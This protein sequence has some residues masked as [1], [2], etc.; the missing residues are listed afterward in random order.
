METSGACLFSDGLYYAE[1]RGGRKYSFSNPMSW[2]LCKEN[3]VVVGEGNETGNHGLEFLF[4][5]AF[6][7]IQ[8]SQTA[9]E[10]ESISA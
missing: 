10:G 2:L 7:Q 6:N 5:S 1:K 4:R 8:H 3:F 9:Q